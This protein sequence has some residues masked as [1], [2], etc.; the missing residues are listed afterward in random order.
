MTEPPRVV[1]WPPPRRPRQN[2]GGLIVVAALA[3]MVFGGGTVLSYYIESMWFDSL[4]YVD[5]FWNT[6]TVRA[7]VFLGF[8]I[9]TF[10]V[11]YG[12]YLALQTCAPRRTDRRSDPD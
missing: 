8:S 11:L 2:R 1:G 3:A 9:A 12:S 4:G 6:L 10:L 5:V 7:A